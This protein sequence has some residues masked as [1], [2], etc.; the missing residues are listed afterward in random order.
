MKGYWASGAG[1]LKQLIFQVFCSKH[2]AGD[3]SRTCR[4]LTVTEL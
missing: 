4:L 2:K 3:R 1:G